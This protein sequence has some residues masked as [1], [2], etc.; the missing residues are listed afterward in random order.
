MHA[1]TQKIT[2]GTALALALGCASTKPAPKELVDAREA[3]NHAANGPAA[4]LVPAQLHLAEEALKGA[5]ECFEDGPE[6]PKTV[7]MAYVALRKAEWAE[8]LGG[9]ELAKQQAGENEK[10]LQ[11]AQAEGAKRALT[12]ARAALAAAQKETQEALGKLSG[13]KDA[14]KSDER[15]VVITLSGSV[16]F[17]S[18]KAVLLPAARSKLE[19]VAKALGSGKSQSILI[20]GHSD[21]TGKTETNAEL[22]Q[23]RA[24][25]VA[26]FLT[27]KGINADRVK[28][29]GMGPARPIADN[30]SAEGRATNRRVEIVVQ[31]PAG[32]G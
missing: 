23:K 28:S 10:G 16:L 5:E 22:S 27:Q 26:K 2:T 9:A 29:V 32:N 19:G 12:A 20:E 18:N 15:G 30:E 25:A 24:D 7:D 6:A 14:V 4:Q 21:A 1:L 13:L 31:A 3:Y 11:E 8:S 17:A